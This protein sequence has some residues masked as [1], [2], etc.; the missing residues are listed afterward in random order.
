M[1]LASAF[2]LLVGFG[3]IIA[4]MFLGGS[5]SAFIDLPSILIVIGGTFCI[6]MIS[7]TVREFLT[8]QSLIFRVLFQR[9]PDASDAA[10]LVLQLAVKAR[11]DGVLTL[12][13]LAR[14]T[15][16]EPFLRRALTLVIDGTTGDEVER[17]MRREINSMNIRH[18]RSAGVLRRAAEVSPAMGLIG[19]LIGLVQMLGRL[20]DP[21][22]IG[23]AMAVAL[24]T[25][26]YG[27]V[28]ANMVYSP[29]ANKLERNSFQE[30]LVYEIYLTAAASIGRQENPRRLEMLLN[31][32]LSP[33]AQLSH[34]D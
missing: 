4:A 16:V 1:D 21:A 22:S 5:P 9:L 31:T 19:T 29:L 3:L 25:T 14:D 28:L 27:A 6:T 8:A 12:Q 10:Y 24:L 7:Y 15:N 11:K 32:I 26:F 13:K 20:D 2:G 23:P 34:F 33:S 18:A 17:T 30:T